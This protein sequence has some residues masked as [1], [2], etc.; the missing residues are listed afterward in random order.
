MF[1][2]Y[3]WSLRRYDLRIDFF[4]MIQ[5]QWLNGELMTKKLNRWGN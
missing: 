4:L 3:A 5:F 1:Q 2:E